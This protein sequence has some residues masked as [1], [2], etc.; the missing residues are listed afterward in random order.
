[1]VLL[2]QHAQRLVL[3]DVGVEIRLTSQSTKAAHTHSAVK[4]TTIVATKFT[5]QHTLDI[6]GYKL[7]ITCYA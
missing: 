4:T 1:V 5:F 6:A 7:Q 3:A 2:W